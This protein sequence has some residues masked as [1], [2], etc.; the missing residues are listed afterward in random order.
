MTIL[1]HL[2]FKDSLMLLMKGTVRELSGDCKGLP[3]GTM[4]TV[5]ACDKAPKSEAGACKSS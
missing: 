4:V 5:I 2:V 3:E 1:Q